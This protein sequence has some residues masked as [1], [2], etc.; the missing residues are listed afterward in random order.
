[1]SADGPADE[2]EAD[3]CGPHQAGRPV[4]PDGEDHR[5]LPGGRGED[6]SSL[7]VIAFVWQL[8]TLIVTKFPPSEMRSQLA[9]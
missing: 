9:I 5:R 4:H 7:S 6:N 3:G 2:R 1:M 8:S